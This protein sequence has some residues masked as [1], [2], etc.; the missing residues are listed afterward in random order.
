MAEQ[1]SIA[2]WTDGGCGVLS[3]SFADNF[4]CSWVFAAALS[5]SIFHGLG[6]PQRV[7]TL[8]VQGHPNP[9]FK[10]LV[11]LKTVCSISQTEIRNF[12]HHLAFECSQLKWTIIYTKKKKLWGKGRGRYWGSF[13]RIFSVAPG[14]LGVLC[15][16]PP[17]MLANLTH[18]LGPFEVQKPA[19]DRSD[20]EFAR[21]GLTRGG[22]AQR[23]RLGLMLFQL[24]FVG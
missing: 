10:A 2:G 23:H 6:F 11:I 16:N 8:G 19:K 7:V 15:W 20:C 12:L 5:P 9:S 4:F 3:F 13:D 24:N 17:K 14:F 18:I 21:A 22:R 1:A